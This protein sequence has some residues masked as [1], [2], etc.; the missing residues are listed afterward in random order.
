MR[1]LPRKKRAEILRLLVG[2]ASLSEPSRICD[3]SIN[4]V[5]KLLRD[6]GAACLAYHD[7]EVR[8]IR[9]YRRVQMD[10]IWSFTHCKEA[11]LARRRAPPPHYAGDTWTWLALDADS[12]LLLSWVI[13]ARDQPACDAIV[14]DLAMRLEDRL[15]LT[16]D[17]QLL[18]RYAVRRFFGDRVDFAH[19]AKQ[20]RRGDE[21]EAERRYSAPRVTETFTRTVSGN[22]DEQ[23]ISTSY[24]ERQN[25]SLRMAVRRLTRLTNAYS[26]RIPNHA[27]HVALYVVWYNFV[28][29]HHALRVTPAME[30]GLAGEVR[31][32]DWIV[33]LI[34]MN[35]PPAA[36]WGTRRRE[37]EVSRRREIEAR[38]AYRVAEDT[39]DGDGETR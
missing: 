28:R 9:G 24:V 20:Y 8:G 36:E 32:F 34:E 2:G 1:R 26:K 14:G 27:W 17:G 22:P 23:H 33:E 30:L 16:T 38:Y 29:I 35:T 7:R 18:Y 31:D 5:V 19:L 10:D 12:R 4:T 25:L 3:V 15:Q 13:G 37:R 11:T 39:P 6:A 21:P